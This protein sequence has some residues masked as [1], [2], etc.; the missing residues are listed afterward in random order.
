MG[1]RTYKYKMLHFSPQH[2]LDMKV[3][4]LLKAASVCVD[5]D[6]T[7]VC[8][9]LVLVLLASRSASDTAPRKKATNMQIVGVSLLCCTRI[10]MFT[11]VRSFVESSVGGAR[12]R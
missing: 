7:L 6:H 1:R 8:F 12:R 4:K 10:A 9:N 2:S 3:G 11:W 5:F